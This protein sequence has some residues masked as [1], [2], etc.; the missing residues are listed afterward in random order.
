MNIG[1][2]AAIHIT[3]KVPAPLENANERAIRSL[4]LLVKFVP[5]YDEIA[6]TQQD[7]SKPFC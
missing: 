4:Y 6:K 7:P 3:D 2:S 5:N 1:Q